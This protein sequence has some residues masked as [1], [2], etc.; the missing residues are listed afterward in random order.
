MFSPFIFLYGPPASGKSV[1]GLRLASDLHLPFYDLDQQI[2]LLAGKSISEIFAEEDERG[3]RTRES[4]ALHEVLSRP[5]GVVA[6]GGG[7]LLHD[8]NRRLA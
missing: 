7:A 5:A 2:E 4:A 8:Q 1:V 6:L 3:F